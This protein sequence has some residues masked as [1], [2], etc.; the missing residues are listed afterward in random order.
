MGRMICFEQ[1]LAAWGTP[2][3]ES[4]LKEE[5][6]RLTL[7]EL[8]LQQGL[9]AG[10]HALEA[11]IQAMVLSISETDEHFVAKA[12]IFYCSVIAGCSCADDPTPIDERNEYCEVELKIDKLSAETTIALLP[13]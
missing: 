12:G 8:P 7:D 10:S 1:A 9:V 2:A 11:G 5:V 6:E 13:R 4:V 3:F